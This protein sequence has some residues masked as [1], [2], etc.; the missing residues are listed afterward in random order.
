LEFK[1][2]EEMKSWTKFIT[3][4]EKELSMKEKINSLCKKKETPTSGSILHFISLGNSIS[5]RITHSENFSKFSGGFNIVKQGK[6]FKDNFQSNWNE[7]YFVLNNNQELRYFQDENVPI[8]KGLFSLVNSYV[9]KEEKKI[10]IEMIYRTYCLYSKDETELDDWIES[11]V[12][13]GSMLKTNPKSGILKEGN[14]NKESPSTGSFQSRN[15]ILYSNGILKYFKNDQQKGFIDVKFS[16]IQRCETK[17]K[18]LEDVFKIYTK[19]RIFYLQG[20]DYNNVTNWLNVL[21]TAEAKLF[22]NE[23]IIHH[24]IEPELREELEE[25]STDSHR[26]KRKS[27]SFDVTKEIGNKLMKNRKSM[28]LNK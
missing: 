16:K 28:N 23:E 20:S 5:K 25:E 12:S 27:I 10:Y 13:Q 6:L 9:W 7:R 22:S 15:F 26:Q 18:E 1:N 21:E 2:E 24:Q 11:L 19:S 14:L 8:M 17:E 4:G 3:V